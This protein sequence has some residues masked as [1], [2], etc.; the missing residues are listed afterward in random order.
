MDKKARED[1]GMTQ[2][3]AAWKTWEMVL[4]FPRENWGKSQLLVRNLLSN[5]FFHND[6]LFIYFCFVFDILGLTT[7]DIDVDLYLFI[8]LRLSCLF[9]MKTFVFFKLWKVLC[10]YIFKYCFW[11]E[12]FL[13]FS[14]PKI[15]AE[16]IGPSF[17]SPWLLNILNFW[18]AS[19]DFNHVILQFI[20][21]S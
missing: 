8:L 2:R 18:P 21:F 7:L 12:T 9:Y 19:C 3:F 15:S 10:H 11:R 20:I 4:P 13:L 17:Y 1:C 5:L 16:Y 14:L 6:C